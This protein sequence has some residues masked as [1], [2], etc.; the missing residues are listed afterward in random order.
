M[1]DSSLCEYDAALAGSAQ[2]IIVSPVGSSFS[3]GAASGQLGGA[4]LST[5]TQNSG[6]EFQFA[7]TIVSESNGLNFQKTDLF[8]HEPL[9]ILATATGRK[10]NVEWEY[11]AT[12]KNF[13]GKKIASIL[14]T[15]KSYF[16]T[17]KFIRYPLV[18]FKY[19]YVLPVL[20]DFRM[21]SCNI[22]YSPEKVNSGGG[23]YPIWSKVGIELEL[24][25][26]L[27]NPQKPPAK[28]VAPGLKPV[29]PDWY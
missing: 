10:I 27:S 25:T 4:G 11:F 12:D 5:N 9:A 15:L 3:S 23:Y 22:T 21:M 29:R 7:P 17:F 19:M 8:S 1:G 20:T 18:K 2:L 26:T 24:A 13:T 16:F 28:N 14:R 6:I